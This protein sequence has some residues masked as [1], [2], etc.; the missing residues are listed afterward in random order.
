MKISLK[1]DCND[2]EVVLINDLYKGHNSV[3]VSIGNVQFITSIKDVFTEDLLCGTVG[4]I[5]VIEGYRK[6]RQ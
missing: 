1:V 3:S 2:D 4:A 6:E 5:V